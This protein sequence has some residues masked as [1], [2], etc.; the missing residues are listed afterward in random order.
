[1]REYEFDVPGRGKVKIQDHSHG[2]SYS[3]PSQNRGP[4]FNTPDDGH[5]DY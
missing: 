4:H 2:H 3:D 1:V 5:Y